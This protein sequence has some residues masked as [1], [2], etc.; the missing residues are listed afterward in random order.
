[1]EWIIKVNVSR[2]LEIYG[3]G[4]IFHRSIFFSLLEGGVS[5]IEKK[6]KKEKKRRKVKEKFDA[7][8][9]IKLHV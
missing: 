2:P 1:M 3:L 8:S 7:C 4:N 6:K 5:M 9:F